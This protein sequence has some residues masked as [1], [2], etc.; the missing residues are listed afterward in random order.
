M[1]VSKLIG[2]ASLIAWTVANPIPERDIKLVK[3]A[4]EGIH[5]VDCKNALEISAVIVRTSIRRQLTS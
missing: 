4:T 3:R 1:F 2:A 5:F